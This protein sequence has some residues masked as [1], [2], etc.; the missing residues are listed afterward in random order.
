[1]IAETAIDPT[2]LS[3]RA[4]HLRPDNRGYA[5]ETLRCSCGF[6]TGAT[7]EAVVHGYAAHGWRRQRKDVA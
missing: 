4:R 3:I 5:A 1:V 6:T 2:V 7:A